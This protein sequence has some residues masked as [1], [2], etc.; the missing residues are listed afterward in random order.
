MAPTQKRLESRDPAVGQTDDRLVIELDFIPI[1]GAAQIRLQRDLIARLPFGEG[2]G[3]QRDPSPTVAFGGDH[4]LLGLRQQI[5]PVMRMRAR[6]DSHARD[7]IDIAIGDGERRGRHGEQG[8]AECAE[9][10]D[11][12]R[13]RGKH[14]AADTIER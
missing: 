10:A 5:G 7:E 11:I 2:L 6:S 9:I 12:K 8:F 3:I 4:R 13:Q 14:V 1:E